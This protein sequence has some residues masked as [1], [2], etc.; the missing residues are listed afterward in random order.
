MKSDTDIILL[1]PFDDG[2][3]YLVE[4]AARRIFGAHLLGPLKMALSEF[5]EHVGLSFNLS[6]ERNRPVFDGQPLPLLKHRSLTAVTLATHLERAGLNWTIIDPGIENLGWWRRRLSEYGGSNPLT[7]GI[8][9]TYMM[10]SRWIRALIAMVRETFPCS[11]L[12]LGGY[13]Y[14]TDAKDF[15]S[16]DGDIFCVGEGEVRLPQVITRIKNGESLD[17]IP[18]LYLDRGD[19]RLD[20]TGK[21]EPLNL[22]QISAVDWKLSG[23]I[24]PAVDIEN[25]MLETGLETQRGCVFKCGFCT[26]RTLSSP[27]VMSAEVA[28]DRLFNTSSVR[29]GSIMMADATATYP[30][31]RWVEILNLLIERGGSPHPIWAYA[32]VS[33]LPESTVELM[34]R[35]GVSHVFIGQESGDQRML[36]RMK[37]GTHVRQIEPAVEAMA[38][39]NITA[40]MAFIHGYP[41]ETM[42]SLQNTRRLLTTI[43]DRHKANPPII[44]Y[45]LHPFLL[46]DMASASQEDFDV[47][48]YVHAWPPKRIAEECLAT[49][50]AVGRIPHA[51][52][53]LYLLGK[54][55]STTESRI[56]AGHRR[57]HEFFRWL[58]TVERGMVM[59]LEQHLEGKKPDPN[60]LRRIKEILG[61]YY[62]RP[63]GLKGRIALAGRSMKIRLSGIIAKRL[64]QEWANEQEQGAGRFT[65]ALVSSMAF[66][67]T[68]KLSAMLEAWRTGAQ[69][70]AAATGDARKVNGDAIAEMANDLINEGIQ[71]GKAKLKILDAKGEVISLRSKTKRS[72]IQTEPQS[73]AM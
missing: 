54:E 19:G 12:I 31:E 47:E 68:G 34:A 7:V 44:L 11:K 20:Y 2:N 21:A 1:I 50:I 26:F 49:I 15:L 9:T 61:E 58:K 69:A 57:P 73:E 5:E 62:V 56:V 22:S 48:E 66:R 33:D 40:I 64:N 42:E 35:A 23:R 70:T 41:G 72:R 71:N 38:K 16:L 27:T 39:H 46:Q 13:Y 53:F 8:S 52:A 55:K 3:G 4:P 29:H 28:V 25:D 63:R 65:R 24:E 60:E 32:R 67:D 18:G 36:N 37:K 10:G 59:F 17:N 6:D 51:P 43:N 14:A 45:T 30:H